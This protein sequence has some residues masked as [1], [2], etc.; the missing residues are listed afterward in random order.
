MALDNSAS[1]RLKH[2]WGTKHTHT[3]A[4]LSPPFPLFCVP[5]SESHAR[6]PFFPFAHPLPFPCPCLA[7][8]LCFLLSSMLVTPV[9]DTQRPLNLTGMLYK[10]VC[11]CV[12]VCVRARSQPQTNL[13]THTSTHASNP[14]YPA[15]HTNNRTHTH[16]CTPTSSPTHPCTDP[17][18]HPPIHTR[19][20]REPND[21][22]TD[23]HS[24]HT[25]VSAGT[26][27]RVRVCLLLMLQLLLSMLSLL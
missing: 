10:G 13:A 15:T 12:C 18:R 5:P 22:T 3:P 11:V 4:S 7:L 25:R 23:N 6:L 26:R 1:P 16:S 20:V 8:P 14:P 21:R 17:P 27:A 2:G 24:T 19:F 9:H